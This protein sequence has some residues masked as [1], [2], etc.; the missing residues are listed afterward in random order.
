MKAIVRNIAVGTVGTFAALAVIGAVA[1]PSNAHKAGPAPAIVHTAPVAQPAK[2]E[3]AKAEP[4][5]AKPVAKPAAPVETTTQKLTDW[6][7]LFGQEDTD[8]ITSDASQMVSA[9]SSGD[10]QG[11]SNAC[12]SLGSDATSAL[13]DPIPN[14]TMQAT[15]AKALRDY[16]RAASE[17]IAGVASQDAGQIDAAASDMTNGNALIQKLAGQV[18]RIAK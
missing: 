16:K 12:T 9:A 13:A 7:G 15:Y 4:V 17:C 10:Y 8:A 5:V 18:T 3:P 1:G 14:P 6:W 11:V 2:A